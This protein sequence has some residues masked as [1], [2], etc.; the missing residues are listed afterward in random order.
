MVMR[1]PLHK[2]LPLSAGTVMRMVFNAG[3]SAWRNFYRYYVALN[4]KCEGLN[5]DNAWP[6]R[7]E[8]YNLLTDVEMLL[9]ILSL[10]HSRIIVY[11]GGNHGARITQFLK[12]KAGYVD[13]YEYNAGKSYRVTKTEMSQDHLWPLEYSPVDQTP[14]L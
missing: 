4:K 14:E 5:E 12:E 6:E 11:C 10:S 9:H 1:G 2:M 3:E 7:F 8:H 13:I